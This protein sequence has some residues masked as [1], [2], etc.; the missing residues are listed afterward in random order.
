MVLVWE[1]LCTSEPWSFILRRERLLEEYR[2]KQHFVPNGTE[3]CTAIRHKKDKNVDSNRFKLLHDTEH[4]DL[5]TSY[6][7][8]YFPVNVTQDAILY[9]GRPERLAPRAAATVANL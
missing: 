3:G 5:N 9:Q 1:C 7:I 2:T 4:N 8:I 6:C